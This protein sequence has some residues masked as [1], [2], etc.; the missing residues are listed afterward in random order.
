MRTLILVFLLTFANA[1]AAC[2]SKTQ[3]GKPA[4]G[5]S[6][7]ASKPGDPDQNPG[8]KRSDS[9]PKAA[10]SAGHGGPVIDLGSTTVN[11]MAVKATRDK[12]E[13]KPGGDAPVDV[14]IDGGLGNAVAVR[15]WIG[16]EDAKGSVKAKAEVEHGKWHTHTE[17]PDPL[18]VESKLWVEIE[19]KDGKK[20]V[21]PFDLMP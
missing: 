21:A 12:G 15:F 20:G 7:A 16:T 4:S 2:D 14:W 10:K 1:L 6:F 13:I 8:E 3:S 9:Q 18:P 17:V 11:G 5:E 19:T